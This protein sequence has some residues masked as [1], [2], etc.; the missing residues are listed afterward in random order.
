MPVKM[1]RSKARSTLSSRP[2][3]SAWSTPKHPTSSS[4]IRPTVDSQGKQVDTYLDDDSLGLGPGWDWGDFGPTYAT[5]TI[6]TIQN[7]DLLI[8]IVDPTKKKIVF[9]AYASGAFQ[10]NPIKEDKTM[11]NAVDKIFKQFPPKEK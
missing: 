11:G 10:S 1:R 6:S 7:G 8:D 3:V 4:P 9:R 2:K 5:S